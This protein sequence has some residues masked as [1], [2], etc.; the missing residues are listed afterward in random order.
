MNTVPDEQPTVT[1]APNGLTSSQDI[2]EID[3][4]P[5]DP[6]PL[7]A[8]ISHALQRRTR[9]RIVTTSVTSYGEYSLSFRVLIVIEYF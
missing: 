4:Q 7:S 8:H 6:V 1:A 9:H 2:V 5:G 3:V